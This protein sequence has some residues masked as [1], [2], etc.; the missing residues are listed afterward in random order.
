METETPRTIPILQIAWARFSELDVNSLARSK[1]HLVKRRWIA[2]LGVLATLFAILAQ[3]F[4]YPPSDNA[5]ALLGLTFRILLILIPLI[6]SA[7]AAFTKAFHDLPRL[8]GIEP[9][10]LP[11]D[12]SWTGA[13][14]RACCRL[15]AML[16]VPLCEAAKNVVPVATTA[17]ESVD[18]LRRWAS[19]RT[20][21]AS[22]PGL[23]VLQK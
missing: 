3:M 18:R 9:Q 16:D 13:E 22:R 4:P 10:P 21:S 1:S 23:Y 8:Y 5:P 11:S 6:A 20:L 2:A 14:V 17:A 19:G 15:S 7:M 12:T